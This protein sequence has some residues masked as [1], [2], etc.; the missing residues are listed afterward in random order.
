MAKVA[1]CY[2]WLPTLQGRWKTVYGDEKAAKNPNITHSWIVS[3]SVTTTSSYGFLSATWSVPPTPPSNDGQILFY[4][5]GLEDINDMVT[6]IQPVLGGM[7]IS[8]QRG[9]S[10]V[11][12]AA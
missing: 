7:P 11:G 9:A 3:E 8:P 2:V 12:I 4:F 1:K 6:I 10:P 5:P